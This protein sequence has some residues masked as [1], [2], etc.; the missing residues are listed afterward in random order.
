VANKVAEHM[1]RKAVMIDKLMHTKHGN[2]GRHQAE[3]NEELAAQD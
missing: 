1:A 2:T 3:M